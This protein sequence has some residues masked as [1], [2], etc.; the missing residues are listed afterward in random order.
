MKE[1]IELS[2]LTGA[3]KV[4]LGNEYAGIFGNNQ[5]IINK[6]LDNSG[7]FGEKVW[8]LPRSKKVSEELKGG[9][10]DLTNSR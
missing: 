2:T 8:N 3:V 7:K 6:F 1:I 10:S 4:A 5:E 9:F